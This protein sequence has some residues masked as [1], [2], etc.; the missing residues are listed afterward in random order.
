M[1]EGRYRH[2]SF[3]EREQI[4]IW[5]LEG[6][7]QAEMAR[8]LGRSSSTINRELARN[9]LPSGGYQPSFA[10]GSYLARRERLAL[11]ER[12]E[13]LERFVVDRLTEGWAPEQIAG[14]LKAGNEPGLR[15]LGTETIYRFIYR[16]RQKFE[17]LWQLLPRGKARRGRRKRRETKSTITDRRSIHERPE[18]VLGREKLGDWEADLMFCRR[19]Q[20]VLVL[21]ERTSRLTL[22][23]KLAGKSAAET[24]ATLMAIFKRLAPE[25]KS[26]IT[27]DNGSE[28]ARH[29]LL[30]SVSGMT[31]WFCDA[32]ASWQKGSVENTNGRL[33]RQLPQA[34]RPRH[35][36]PGR[37]PGHRPLAQP[38]ATQM[39]R[40]PTPIQA[41][42][43]GLGK[44][45]QSGS[46]DAPASALGTGIHP[47][48]A[49]IATFEH[50]AR[51]HLESRI[52]YLFLFS[53]RSGDKEH[54]RGLNHEFW[55]QFRSVVGQKMTDH[56]VK[57]SLCSQ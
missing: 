1:G 57:S 6:V 42:F 49:R 29:G 18:A 37:P 40:L 48:T 23:A 56:V 53:E 46:L 15:G 17:K 9:R 51:R 47:S 55:T 43:K 36:E 14:W 41:F 8:R 33:R 16:A 30:A 38:H 34:S 32:Y 35:R 10:E 21:H 2:L 3:E 52:E 7:S 12:D 19:T 20:P 5:R 26:S 24:A 39:P 28:F 25:L 50:V 44:D 54:D 13:R 31:T 4:A 22:A 27:F 45:I 11:L